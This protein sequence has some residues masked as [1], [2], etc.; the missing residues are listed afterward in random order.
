MKKILS[1]LLLAAGCTL[2]PVWAADTVDVLSQRA[3]LGS[4]AL[5][6]VLLDVNQAGSRLVAVG[7]RGVVLLSDD[8]GQHWRQSA[9][10]VST[11]LTSVQFVDSKN[12]W[13][14]GHSGVVLH[15]SDGGESWQLQ[16]DGK[17]AAAIELQAAEHSG[18]SK[19]I[20]AA[21][22]LS[23][24]GADK[25]LL[26]VNFVDAEHGVA[27]GAYGLALSTKDGGNTWQSWMSDLPN[28]RG[29]HLY[30]MARNGDEIIIAGEQGLL[31]R[32]I[33]NG[34]KF[35]AIK[36]PYEGSYFA[37]AI[38]PNKRILVGGLRGKLFSSDDGGI[39]FQPVDNPIPASLNAIRIAGQNLLLVNQAGIL[40]KSG[41]TDLRFQPIAVSEGLPLT[42]VTN[43][44]DGALVAVGV[45]GA[46]RLAP[47]SLTKIA[48]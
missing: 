20:A 37:A 36:G 29:L 7:E 26:V 45:A 14:V 19:R 17:Q 33:D 6:A 38:L 2:L 32:S 30:A 15:S 44:A 46:R 48:D 11:T 24:D 21:Q 12:G 27:L 43:T 41:L 39:S 1:G 28:P 10:P 31:L 23:A 25:P 9:S 18:D 40:L 42:A 5:H 3:V 35:E 13:A 16:L 8:G 4:Q 34:L 22:R 47:S